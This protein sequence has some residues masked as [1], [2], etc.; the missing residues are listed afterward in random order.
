MHI[1]CSVRRIDTPLVLFFILIFHLLSFYSVT[2]P[3]PYHITTHHLPSMVTT[4][5]VKIYNRLLHFSHFFL[6]NAAIMRS[7]LHSQ[8][9]P[10]SNFSTDIIPTEYLRV[11]SQYL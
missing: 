7:L 2:A 4:Y 5:T 1:H 9:V 3:T 8:D 10:D 6:P 11:F